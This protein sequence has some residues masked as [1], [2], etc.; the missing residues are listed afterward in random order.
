[1]KKI[2]HARLD[3]VV[4]TARQ[5]ADARAEGYR[6]KA[7]KLYPWMLSRFSAG[8]I[9]LREVYTNLMRMV[10]ADITSLSLSEKG[11]LISNIS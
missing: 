10:M 3:H 2:D 5:A 8:T 11:W 4:L 9:L 6:E 1:M 7:L